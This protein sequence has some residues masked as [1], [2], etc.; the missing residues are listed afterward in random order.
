MKHLIL[1]QRTGRHLKNQGRLQLRPFLRE[2]GLELGSALQWWQRELCRDPAVTQSL[3]TNKYEYQILH[4]YGKRGHGRVA[5]AFSCKRIIGFPAP[6][7]NQA[8]GCPFSYMTP[9][10]LPGFLVAWGVPEGMVEPIIAQVEQEDPAQACAAFFHATHP[11]AAPELSPAGHPMEF[12][13]CSCKH[14]SS[15]NL[16]EA[17]EAASI[18]SL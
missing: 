12:T 9:E 2:A 11:G 15:C 13:R 17:A 8:H 7:P 14:F 16:A 3:F 4:A 5:Y 1:H 10:M 18:T 6:M